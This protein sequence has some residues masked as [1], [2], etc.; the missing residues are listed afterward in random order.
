[1]R[2]RA[3]NGRRWNL[4]LRMMC[5][6]MQGLA[7]AEECVEWLVADVAAV[8]LEIRIYAKQGGETCLNTEP[9]SPRYATWQTKILFFFF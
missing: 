9:D 7:L 8:S 5:C 3:E 1:L 4:E 6:C 2:S